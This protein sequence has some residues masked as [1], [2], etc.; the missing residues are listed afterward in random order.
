M[1]AVGHPAKENRFMLPLIGA[2]AQHKRVLDPDADAAD[3]E[4][5]LLECPAEV[6]PFRV[7][8]EDMRKTPM[9]ISS[10][11]HTIKQPTVHT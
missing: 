11:C 7:R 1:L 6:E 9:R 10:I 3:V 8:M 2:S 5:G 4:A